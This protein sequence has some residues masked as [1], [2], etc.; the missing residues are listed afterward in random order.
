M[1]QI[2]RYPRAEARRKGVAGIPLFR[3]SADFFVATGRGF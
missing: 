2:V 3:A 1:W